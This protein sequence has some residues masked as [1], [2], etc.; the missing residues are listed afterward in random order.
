MI[1]LS[2]VSCACVI[3]VNDESTVGVYPSTSPAPPQ[4]STPAFTLGA[5]IC[6]DPNVAAFA[7]AANA[8]AASR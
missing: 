1:A 5:R 3:P 7:G 6:A 2:D 8:A 4:H